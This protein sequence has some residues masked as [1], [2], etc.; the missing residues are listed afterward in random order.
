MRGGRAID[1]NCSADERDPVPPRPDEGDLHLEP[2]LGFGHRRLSIIDLASGL[3]PLFNEDR[4]R[5]VVFNGEIYNFREL[6]RRT[7]GLG[8]EFRTRCD[9]ETIVHAWEAMG[10]GLRAA[11]ARHVRVRDLGPQQAVLF[12]ARDRLGIKP[13]TTRVLPD[14]MFIFGSELKSLRAHA[15]PAARDRPLRGRGIFRLRLRAGAAHHL[16]GA[17]KLLPGHTLTLKVGQPHRAEE[18][19]GRAVQPHDRMTERDMPKAS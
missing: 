2:G 8:H 1:R 6:M 11:P 9:T 5:G 12:M 4:Q 18:I 10:R 14:G 3:Q 19:L 16:Q 17:H 13:C 7:A 15:G